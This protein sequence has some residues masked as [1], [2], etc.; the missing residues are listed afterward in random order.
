MARDLAEA[1][2]G[3][4]KACVGLADKIV[5]KILSASLPTFNAERYAQR[6]DM[7]KVPV[8]TVAT[9]VPPSSTRLVNFAGQIP[10]LATET[11]STTVSSC[12]YAEA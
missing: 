10:S 7:E 1:N 2:N 5:V 4:Q 8:F 11:A 3:Q 12:K 6:L 9:V